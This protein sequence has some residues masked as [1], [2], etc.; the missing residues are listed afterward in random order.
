MRARRTEGEIKWI[1]NV[2]E[3]LP[4]DGWSPNKCYKSSRLRVESRAAIFVFST[5]LCC[6]MI[7]QDKNFTG[8][9]FCFIKNLLD[10]FYDGSRKEFFSALSTFLARHVLNNYIAR[11]NLCKISCRSIDHRIGFTSQTSHS[12]TPFF[13]QSMFHPSCYGPENRQLWF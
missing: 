5:V 1:V 13:V 4:I 10:T 2:K 9:L 6:W 3:V 8:N 12:I 11:G 7:I